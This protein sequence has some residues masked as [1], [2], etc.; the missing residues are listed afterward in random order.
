MQP[1]TFGH[2]PQ[3]ESGQRGPRRGHRLASVASRDAVW[4]HWEQNYREAVRRA[5]YGGPVALRMTMDKA[6]R[7]VEYA[8]QHGTE[9][10]VG[11]TGHE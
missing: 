10:T 4:A 7:E 1:N 3:A 6:R 9:P 11:V 2:V 5:R 8:E